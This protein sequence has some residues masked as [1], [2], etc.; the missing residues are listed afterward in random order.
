MVDDTHGHEQS[1]A[2]VVD[3]RSGSFFESLR[4]VVSDGVAAAVRPCSSSRP[5]TTSWSGARRRPGGRTRCRPAAG[6]S[7]GWPASAR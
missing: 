6:C 4:E 3:V 5:T 1:I 2:V 7:T